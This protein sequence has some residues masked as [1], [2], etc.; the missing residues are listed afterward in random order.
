MNEKTVRKR[1]ERSCMDKKTV[2]TLTDMFDKKQLKDLIY[3]M[4]SERGEAEQILLDYCQKKEAGQKFGNHNLII[5]KQLR[6]HW[7]KASGIIE[8]FDMY[9]G[10]PEPDEEDAYD[11]LEAMEELLENNEISWEVRQ[12][13]LD[14]ML[15]F[16]AS[17]NS[18][19]TDGLVDIAFVL[20]R[21]K[22]EYLYLADFLNS[23]GNSYYRNLA[24]DIYLKNGEDEKFIE[25]KKA[26]L[27]YG[28]DYLELAG[29]YEKHGDEKK[30]LKI[31]LEGLNK[32]NGRLDEIYSY[33]FNYYKRKKDETA[34]EKL[35]KDSKKRKWNQDT[36]TELMHQY[37][38]EKGDYPKQK[39]MLL[40]LISCPGRKH[41]KDL[42]K[43]CRDELS[44]KDFQE[45]EGKILKAVKKN[46]L[47]A[48]FDILIEKDETGEVIEYLTSHPQRG[49]WGL[50]VDHYFSK[51]LT[52]KYPREIVELYWGE[53]S[54]YVGLGKE[55]N[56]RHAAAILKEI[57]KLMAKNQ[58]AEEWKSRYQTF[59]EVHKRKR[60]LLGVLNGLEK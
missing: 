52:G 2:N 1:R 43:K 4:V 8:E 27:N 9:G 54:F 31:V 20:C 13:V 7:K 15:Y 22:E 18:G 45:E 51:R 17:D 10:G 57:R 19:F 12:E 14:E 39:E 23:K 53:V 6:K 48:Y 59:L 24:A 50:D 5:E 34:L 49:G 42:Y 40:E 46:D 25:S 36:M 35:Y 41:M 29:Y 32:C 47:S 33:L 55:S 3:H 26:N 21:T 37:Y 16:V 44:A 11:E 28:S 38:T 58:W 30:A 56:Y 60:L